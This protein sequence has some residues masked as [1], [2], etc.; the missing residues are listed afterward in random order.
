MPEREGTGTHHPHLMGV[1]ATTA[2]DLDRRTILRLNSEIAAL[3]AE[4]ADA[5]EVV[6]WYNQLV[7][8]AGIGTPAVP[9]LCAYIE[10]LERKLEETAAA[11][12][13]RE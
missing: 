8:R 13:P 11:I 4:L 7:T 6:Q 3:K 10:R 5:Q 2:A 12:P 9:S 1:S